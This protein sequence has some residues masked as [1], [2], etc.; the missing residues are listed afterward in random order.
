M[1]NL[2]QII[3]EHDNFA[4]LGYEEPEEDVEIEE[5]GPEQFGG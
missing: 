3:P 1:T 5:E 4:A 2:F